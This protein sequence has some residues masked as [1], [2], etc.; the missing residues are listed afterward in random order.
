MLQIISLTYKDYCSE[1][2]LQTDG[3][4]LCRIMQY[5]PSTDRRNPTIVLKL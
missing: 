5:K 4:E 3:E 2:G 1:K